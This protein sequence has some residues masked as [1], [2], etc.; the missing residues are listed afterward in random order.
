M[1]GKVNYFKLSSS[2]PIYN[3]PLIDRLPLGSVGF[4]QSMPSR[5]D[6][7][8][9]QKYNQRV[10]AGYEVL[11]RYFH[12]YH[13]V[14]EYLDNPEVLLELP[15]PHRMR[16][17]ELL[18]GTSDDAAITFDKLR[19]LELPPDVG[20]SL[21]QFKLAIIRHRAMKW[22]MIDHATLVSILEALLNFG[23]CPGEVIDGGDA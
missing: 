4:G 10:V 18:H 14:I 11:L 8:E 22:E 23:Q 21:E 2:G 15:Q 5:Q 19:E 12:F 3:V 7:I 9:V 13:A 16:L 1:I 20:E 17:S 6:L